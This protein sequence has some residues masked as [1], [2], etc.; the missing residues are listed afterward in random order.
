MGRFAPLYTSALTRFFGLTSDSRRASVFFATAAGE[1]LSDSEDRHLQH[2]TVAPYFWIEPTSVIPHRYLGTLADSA[3]FDSVTTPGHEITQPSFECIRELDSGRNA[4]F[5]TVMFKMRTARTS[6]LVAAYAAK[7]VA[8]VTLKLYQFDDD[9]IVL[10][11]N[12]GPTDGDEPTKHSQADPLPSYLWERGQSCLPAPA[13]F[14]NTQA[15][16]AAKYKLVEWDAD[17]AATMGVLP[18]AWELE[19]HPIKWRSSIP[20]AISSGRS[21][22]VDSKARRAFTRGNRP[23][24]GL[25]T[26]TRAV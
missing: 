12:R 9:S 17:F 6:G 11:G 24:P 21:N 23:R 5:S 13:E 16:Y 26:F 20:S 8:L 19:E 14:I 7:P 1:E 3:G 4:N 22:A 15:M 25:H 2:K 18:E 10:A